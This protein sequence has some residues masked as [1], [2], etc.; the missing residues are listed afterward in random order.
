LRKSELPG[1]LILCH[2]F[3]KN[4]TQVSGGLRKKKRKKGKSPS[5]QSEGVKD[6]T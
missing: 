2:N 3:G 5:I 1:M 6:V 4:V